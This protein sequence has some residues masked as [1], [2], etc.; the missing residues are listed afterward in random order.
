M[1][2][3]V[4]DVDIASKREQTDERNAERQSLMRHEPV[5]PLGDRRDEGYVVICPAHEQQ[6]GSDLV[7]QPC[8]VRGA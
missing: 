2:G 6:D 1:S 7:M 3:E 5:G 8:R 4:R